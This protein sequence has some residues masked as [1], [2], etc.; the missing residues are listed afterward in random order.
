MFHLS[1]LSVKY[2]KIRWETH[3]NVKGKK[4]YSFLKLVDYKCFKDIKTI[5]EDRN[6]KIKFVKGGKMGRVG[7]VQLIT[8][9]IWKQKQNYFAA[10][11]KSNKI[12][13][14]LCK[15]L[16]MY[17]G[18]YLRVILSIIVWYFIRNLMKLFVVF[19]SWEIVV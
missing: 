8:F 1:S 6:D 12:K 15:L 5:L 17:V 10:T 2:S 3:D 19:F 18:L 11:Y 9:R 13:L 16:L 4:K 14:G 7:K